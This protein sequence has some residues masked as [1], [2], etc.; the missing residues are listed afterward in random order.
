MMSLQHELETDLMT[1]VSQRSVSNLEVDFMRF[2]PGFVPN[3]PI[4]EK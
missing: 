2:T 1:A 4:P 3:K